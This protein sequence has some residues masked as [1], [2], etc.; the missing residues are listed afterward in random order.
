[1]VEATNGYTD[2]VTV[3]GQFLSLKT[4]KGREKADKPGEFWPDRYNVN[5]LIGDRTVTVS[6]RSE[7][8]ALDAIGAPEVMDR[9]ALPVYV[10]A[11]KSFVFYDGRAV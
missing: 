1:M 7:N 2:G 11:A 8:Q 10:R 5:L 3:V 9:L 4:E 6:Y